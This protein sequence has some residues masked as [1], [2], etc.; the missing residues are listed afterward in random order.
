M[1]TFKT[2][3]LQQQFVTFLP[4]SNSNNYTIASTT[5]TLD[6]RKRNPTTMT[7]LPGSTMHDENYGEKVLMMRSMTKLT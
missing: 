3:N 7:L 2:T 1:S 4:T 5:S 6:R